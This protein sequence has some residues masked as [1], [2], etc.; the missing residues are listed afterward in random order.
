MVK[1]VIQSSPFTNR[2]SLV[3][4]RYLPLT[5]SSSDLRQPADHV[6]NH[7]SS[8]HELKQASSLFARREGDRG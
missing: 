5:D 6:I 4:I 1:R 7:Q 3:N 2:H 8:T